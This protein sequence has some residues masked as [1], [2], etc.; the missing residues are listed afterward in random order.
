MIS[1]PE[2]GPGC[3]TL[4]SLGRSRGFDQEGIQTRK[5]S[6]T[7]I[8]FWFGNGLVWF[9]KELIRSGR[10][11]V[12]ERSGSP[13]GQGAWSTWQERLNSMGFGAKMIGFHTLIIGFFTDAV[14]HIRQN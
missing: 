10:G 3:L 8:G 11:G 9:E 12:K 2:T 6:W 5:R 7:F 4:E 1:A 14:S 13:Y